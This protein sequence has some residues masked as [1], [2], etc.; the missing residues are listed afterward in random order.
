MIHL[1]FYVKKK[2]KILCVESRGC[3][4][5][6]SLYIEKVSQINGLLKKSCKSV[7]VV[8]DMIHRNHMAFQESVK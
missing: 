3:L 8:I 2:M 5:V 7:D 4:G 1:G 6:L